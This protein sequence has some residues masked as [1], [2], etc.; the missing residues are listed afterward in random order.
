MQDF[1]ESPHFTQWSFVSASGIT[2][3]SAAIAFAGYIY[4]H[5]HFEPWES[6]RVGPS[7]EI[8]TDLKRCRKDL[9]VRYKNRKST[10]DC[11]F[12]L[13]SVASSVN[14]EHFGIS[15]V[16]ICNIV[17]VGD[18]RFKSDEPLN[19]GFEGNCRGT[20]ILDREVREEEPEVL[21]SR[22]GNFFQRIIL[23]LLHANALA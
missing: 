12:G 11:V 9:F 23:L 22:R 5:S 17:E 10:S 14:D 13:G 6:V 4:T 2:L 21:Q 1:V 15:K 16:R 18:V 3:L 20:P 7:S 8:D 19:Q